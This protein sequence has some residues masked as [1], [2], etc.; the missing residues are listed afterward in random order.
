MRVYIAEKATKMQQNYVLKYV[1]IAFF[2]L[3]KFFE[4]KSYD[5]VFNSLVKR[6]Q[7][8]RTPDAEFHPKRGEKN[9]EII[10]QQRK[11]NKRQ[12]TNNKYFAIITYRVC[13]CVCV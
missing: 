7:S 10:H 9:D 1:A 12:I 2:H 11:M 13:V 3:W 4:E 6:M 8:Q 5:N